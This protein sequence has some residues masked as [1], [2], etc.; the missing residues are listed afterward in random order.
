ML[1]LVCELFWRFPWQVI[2]LLAAGMV[3]TGVL[4]AAMSLGDEQ[5]DADRRE[6]SRVSL[7]AWACLNGGRCETDSAAFTTDGEGWEL[8]ASPLFRGT[9]L[10]VGH[11]EGVEVGITC[12]M[13]WDPEAETIWH[14]TVLVR[15]CEER[16]PARLRRREIHRLGLPQD[17]ASVAMGGRELCV[18]YAG[19]PEDFVALNAQ[20]DAA[21]RLAASL[22]EA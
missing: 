21:V 7:L 13:G 19:W 1:V 15:L 3:V 22:Q 8:P 10:A 5:R 9:L 6:S 2:V 14:M 16:S 4:L 20:V 12:S 11:R 18:R 17:V